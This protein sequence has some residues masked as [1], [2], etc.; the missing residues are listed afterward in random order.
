[1]RSA[2]EECARSIL[3]TLVEK[4]VFDSALHR[5][6]QDF[7]WGALFFLQKVDNLF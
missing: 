6:S 2:E 7:V 5:R 4:R 1:M 3:A